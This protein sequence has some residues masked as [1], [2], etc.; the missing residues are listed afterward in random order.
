MSA[1]RRRTATTSMREKP[2]EMS[3]VDIGGGRQATVYDGRGLRTIADALEKLRGFGGLPDNGQAHI[4]T[5]PTRLPDGHRASFVAVA[6]CA[7]PLN[8]RIAMPMS[9]YFE[10][11]ETYGERKRYDISELEQAVA[12][13]DGNIQLADGRFI[14]AVELVPI[15]LHREL[16]ETEL[17]IVSHTIRLH[18]AEDRCCRAIYGE[19]L[20]NIRG[21]DFSVL[22]TIQLRGLK[23]IE[24]YI[25]ARMGVGRDAIA[26]ALARAG[27]RQPR[28]GRY[29][30]RF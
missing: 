25:T 8:V 6:T 16:T 5:L 11:A 22:P 27:M 29:A 26:K 9:A 15:K 2:L 19:L 10:A 18:G 12:D 17:R 20:P 1:G 28:S 30:G 24:T 21:L 3:A 4:L 7:G 13:S 23:E 14:H